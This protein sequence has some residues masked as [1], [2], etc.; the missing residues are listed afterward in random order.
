MDTPGVVLPCRHRARHNVC[1]CLSDADGYGVRLCGLFGLARS[2]DAWVAPCLGFISACDGRGGNGPR[3]S[4]RG[5]RKCSLHV[6][7]TPAGKLLLLSWRSARRCWLVDLD[8]AYGLAFQAL[9]GRSPWSTGSSGDVCHDRG[10]PALGVDIT[11]CKRRDS[12]PHSTQ[13]LRL[14][15]DGRP[16]TGPA[17]I[18]LDAS[19][20]RLFLADTDLYFVLRIVAAGGRRPLV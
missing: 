9:E 4:R 16:R 3:A 20:H 5:K 8:R 13:C 7:S 11:W 18:F 6:L 14:D 19:C 17:A 10:S 1:L 15:A 12:L 2:A